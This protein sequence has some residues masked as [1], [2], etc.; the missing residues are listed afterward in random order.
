MPRGM[1]GYEIL[2]RALNPLGR[3]RRTRQIQF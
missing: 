3:K 2:K 1:E